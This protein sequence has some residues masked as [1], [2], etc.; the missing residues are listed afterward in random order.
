MFSWRLIMAPP[1]VLYYVAAHEVVHLLHLNH[2]NRFWEELK[3]LFGDY[4]QQQSWLRE[5]GSKLHRY[6]FSN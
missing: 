4:K 3:N 2:T 6:Q 5:N 1:E